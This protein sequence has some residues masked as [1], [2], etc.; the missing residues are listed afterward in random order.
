MEDVREQLLV[1][2]AP[3]TV[4]RVVRAHDRCDALLGN[5]AEVRE[6]DLVER[7]LVSG[8]VHGE[9]RVLHRV[10][11]EVLHARH[12]VPF[13][14]DKDGDI[15]YVIGNMGHNNKYRLAEGKPMQLYA[16]DMDKNGSVDLIPAYYIRNANGKEELYPALDRNQ[17][18]EQVPAVK[19][20]YLLHK[21]YASVTMQQ[22]LSD[23]GKD[24]WTVL[25]CETF[26]TVWI[27]NLGN[28]TFETHA[29][30]VQA[31][32]APVNSILVEDIDAD[33][34]VDLILTGNEYQM[35]ANTGRHD[36]S[37]GLI[38]KGNG[39]GEFVPISATESGFLIDGDIKDM[40]I[41]PVNE[42]KK[43]LLVAPNDSKLKTFTITT[44]FK[45]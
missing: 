6:V 19:K 16:K 26:S 39:K 3:G 31:Q 4:E 24:D 10:R 14:V 8:D 7:P 2:A 41:V 30:P 45:K 11:G 40:K 1:L 5:V 20:K 43:I 25:T 28:G 18:A 27:E 21:D 37:Y 29:L 32:L 36:A 9:P 23:F 15:D 33:G 42:R 22:L 34:H 44:N 38:L 13:D 12:D 17:L 35:A